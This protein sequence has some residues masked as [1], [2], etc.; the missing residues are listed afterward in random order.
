MTETINDRVLVYIGRSPKGDG[1][2]FIRKYYAMQNDDGSFSNITLTG[3]FPSHC[4]LLKGKEGR[5]YLKVRG[6]KINRQ[7]KTVEKLKRKA[8][9]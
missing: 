1:S 3:P 6:Y 5:S 9:K 2:K 7:L 4:T 8:K